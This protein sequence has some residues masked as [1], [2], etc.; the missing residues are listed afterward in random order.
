[1]T[2]QKDGKRIFYNTKQ[3]QETK[4]VIKTKTRQEAES[5]I[6]GFADAAILIGL[7]IQIIKTIKM[8]SFHAFT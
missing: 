5:G 4:L 8:K 6:I 2:S 7:Y 3:Y 1:M